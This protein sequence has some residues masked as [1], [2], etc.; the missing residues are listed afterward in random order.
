[1]D[2]KYHPKI[3]G[4]R[5]K[6]VSK[7]RED[8]DVQVTMPDKDSD[9]IV[10]TGLEQNTLAARDDI[11]R[12][13]RDYVSTADAI[14]STA[15]FYSH[16]NCKCTK[17]GRCIASTTRRPRVN[18]RGSLGARRQNQTEIFLDHDKM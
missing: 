6:V 17:L 12:I 3:I 5:G 1:V 10:I 11:L 2:A 15:V 7:I 13:V 4:R 8:H 16:G 18:H 9:V 14:T